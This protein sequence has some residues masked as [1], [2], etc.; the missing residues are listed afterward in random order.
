MILRALL[1][2]VLACL[3]TAAT[4]QD[5]PPGVSYQRTLGGIS[6]YKLA[7]GLQVLLKPQANQPRTLLTITYRV[8]SRDEGPGET[9]MAHLLEHVTF[10]GTK[11]SADLGAAQEQ[12][13]ARFNGTTSFDR[14][15]YT[16]SFSPN[17]TTLASLLKLE[18]QRMSQARL[19]AADFAKEKPIV[20]SEMGLRGDA[21][22]G[23]MLQAALGGMFRNHPYGHPVI[24]STRDIETVA[25][26]TLRAFYER[27]YRPDNAV[28]MLAG[29]F[30]IAPT[31][32][33]VA[34]AF[35]SLPAGRAALPARNEREGPQ[36]A[37]RLVTLRTRH[38]AIAV[39]WRLPSL[40][41]EDAAACLIGQN[42]ASAFTGEFSR[43]LPQASTTARLVDIEF[44]RDPFLGGAL[45][46]LPET[47]S[48]DTDSRREL[49]G[50]AERWVGD[51][52]TI[53]RNGINQAVV[54]R[55][56]AAA[57]S[58]LRQQLQSPER[59]SALISDAI[60]AGDWRLPFKLLDAL[61]KVQASE[62]KAV[63]SRYFRAENRTTVLGVTDA[64]QTE[65]S[66]TDQS[67]GFF[68]KLFST[69]AEVASVQ[70]PGQ[71]LDEVGKPGMPAAPASAAAAS[72]VSRMAVYNDPAAIEKRVQRLTLPNGMRLATL[73]RLSVGDSITATLLL[74]WGRPTDVADQAAWRLL[75]N[76]LLDA[77][78]ATLEG[79]EMRLLK[80]QLQ[81]E[82]SFTSG[83]QGLLASV[84]TRGRNL[85][86][87]LALLRDT[88][89][90]PE[91]PRFQFE[92]ERASQLA[93]LAA[94]QHRP[95]AAA[96][97]QR[98][99]HLNSQRG[100]KPGDADYEYSNEE[101]AAQIRA[102]DLDQVRAFQRRWWRF[103]HVE[104][105]VVGMVPGDTA[106]A[107]ERL[108][109]TAP[110]AGSVPFELH[111]S[112]F[113]PIAG[114][115]FQA[116]GGGSAAVSLQQDLPLSRSSADYPAMRL[117]VK[118]LSE[119]R[120]RQRLRTQDAISYDAR[121]GLHVPARGELARITL[122]AI[123]APSQA[124]YI[125]QTIKEEL[126][127]LLADG[128]TAAEL[129]A[130]RSSLLDE[131]RQALGSNAVLAGMLVAQFGVA[132]LPDETFLTTQARDME[133][134]KAVTPEQVL[135]ALRRLVLPE[136]WVTLVTGAQ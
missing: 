82:F 86:R 65:P 47:Q 136:R 75:S 115:H 44:T 41:H 83:P 20:L 78:A 100:L 122:S 59:A 28:L 108:F 84:T 16:S 37:P 22:G 106:A 57:V 124:G 40:A 128:V 61:P 118:V 35:G 8:G 81:A 126:A 112:P 55:S 110:R 56:A 64:A 32:A 29:S 12:A 63:V 14:T 17:A 99:Q 130:A 19:D 73:N 10:R 90:R 101:L 105:A 131:A 89:E 77:G 25:L 120:L 3:V 98:R 39:A 6:E 134:M 50:L 52:G 51:V 114:A 104:M 72:G 18:A 2:A 132:S 94:A 117:A 27:Y 45:M 4:A 54:S 88:I 71:G 116:S 9:G 111:L 129:D 119:S 66:V 121:G 36:T 26:P 74:H 76:Q 48:G 1:S 67:M 80:R 24:G 33:A 97:E 102:L 15:N 38:S 60:G 123:G 62:V 13:G 133:R 49:E 30:D 113:R 96:R 79:D 34:E 125:E 43:R 5:L 70:N 91:L 103:E 85:V 92:R 135:Q 127:R 107:A 68:G 21:V 93:V 109:D 31:L 42:L 95:D 53:L 87:A 11:D 46:E 7:N 58:H 69:P 23:Q